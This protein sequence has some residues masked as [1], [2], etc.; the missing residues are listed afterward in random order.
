[1]PRLLRLEALA[2]FAASA[3]V[4]AGPAAVPEPGTFELL[5]LGGIVALVS[6]IRRRRRKKGESSDTA[7][8]GRNP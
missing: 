1:M 7:S 6:G 4:W 5:A 3:P 2:L 8:P